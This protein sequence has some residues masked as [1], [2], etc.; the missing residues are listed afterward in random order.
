MGK[1]Q[2]LVVEDD[3]AIRRGVVDAL[4]FSGYATFQASRGDEG[5]RLA[6]TVDCDL[7]LLDLVLPGGNGLEI[8]RE[9]RAA[10]P[11]QSPR[12]SPRGSRARARRG[13]PPP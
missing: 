11:T 1:A 6:L 4:E 12:G 9:V 10:R 2:V 8:L 7:L 3:E 5:L 13:S